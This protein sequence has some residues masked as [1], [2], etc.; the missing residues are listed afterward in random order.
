M[1]DAV[2][3]EIDGRRDELLD[4]C[5]QC[6]RIPA[7]NP[8]G[9]TTAIA[10]HARAFLERHG[11]RADVH[12]PR[13]GSPN[14]VAT[15]GARD[16]RPN[17]VVNGHLDTFPVAAGPWAHG[18]PFS[19]ARADGRIYGCGASDMRG[20][21]AAILFAAAVLKPREDAFAG[22][23]TLVLSSDEE[24]GGRFGTGWLLEHV[25]GVAGDA[26]L[27]A[28]QCGTDRVAVGE[29]GMCFLTVRTRGR[30]SHAAY[31]SAESANHRLLTVA[32]A[33]LALERLEPPGGAAAT[34]G[35]EDRVTVNV[36]RLEGGV[37][38]N[39]VAGAALARIDLRL[40]VW[41]STAGLL[42]EVDRVVQQTRVECEIE[43]DLLAEPNATAVD[44]PVV[45]SAL[46]AARLAT[47]REARPVV[48]VGASD[49]RLF[50]AAGVPTAVYGP[51]P[52]NMGAV[53]EFVGCEDVVTTARVH[54]AVMLDA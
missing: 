16:A 36:G 1:R 34:A 30:S 51:A 21:L 49:A 37:S 48:R 28:D 8:P 52:N 42:A 4:L 46:G 24:T 50:R 33:M 11:V 23:V 9:D 43:V 40:P 41:L 3:A 53:D 12:E 31:G 38:P 27:V 54:A 14:L 7:V 5:A 10:A 44:A 15:L 17:L 13:A 19:G 22:R 32:R 2:R 26:C 20:G 18:D 45:R 39:L 47:G 35:P 29:K 6:V 25:E